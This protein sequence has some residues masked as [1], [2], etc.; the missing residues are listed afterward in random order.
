[1]KRVLV[2][3]GGPAGSTV[4][5]LLAK[6]FDVTLIQDKKDFDKPC[7]GGVK[8]K[9]FSQ[10]NLD[11]NLI[12][13]QLSFV[14]MIYKNKKIKIPLKGKNLSIV[15][16][17]EFDNYLRELAQKEGAK[18]YYG[19]LKDIKKNTAI[20]KINDLIFKFQFDILIAADGVNSTTRKILNLPKIPSTITHY[21]KVNHKMDTCYFYFDKEV[22][23]NYYAWA[24]PHNNQTHIGTVTKEEFKNLTKKLNLKIDKIK[25]Y[26]IPLW[27]EDIIYQK[28]NIFF[29]GDAAGQVMPL[30]FEGIYYAIHSAKI[31]A[32]SII[33]NLDYKEE[34]N[35]RFLK[36]FK[37]LYKMQQFMQKEL[38]RNIIINMQK[39]SF[40]KNF[41][42]NLWL[43]K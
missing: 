35:K 36:E 10:F 29:V 4:A 41:S 25:G 40:I 39:I 34:W 11:T 26:K 20:I 8:T 23:G 27:Q 17:K 28:N 24:F 7:G 30:S 5:R 9:I 33:K 18:L 37:L 13:H 14:Y 31:L 16:R 22:A 2:V 6:K 42:V 3:G 12:K 21:A 32:N 19:K 43:G 38:S 1:M 15:L